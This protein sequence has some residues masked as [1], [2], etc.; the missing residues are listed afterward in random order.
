MDPIHFL[1]TLE[2]AANHTAWE[3]LPRIDVPTLIVAAD[4]D[5]F[6]PM[7]L[8]ERMHRAIPGSEMLVVRSG[9]HTAVIEMPELIALRIERFIKERIATARAA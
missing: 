6:T 3:H 7:W 4:H 8:S 5:S 1:H 9:T 2:S